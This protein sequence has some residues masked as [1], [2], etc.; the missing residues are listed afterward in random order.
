M[1]AGENRLGLPPAGRRVCYFAGRP[2]AIPEGCGIPRKTGS[3]AFATGAGGGG[4]PAIGVG[5]RTQP[6][7]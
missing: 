7:Q 6:A 3:A 1:K 4:G 5:R 2:D